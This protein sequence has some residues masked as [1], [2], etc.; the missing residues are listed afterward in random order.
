MKELAGLKSLHSLELFGTDVTD[1]GLKELAG[2][3]SLRWLDLGQTQVT[4]A[5]LDDLHALESLQ[6]LNLRYTQ[7]TVAGVAELLKALP[8]LRVF[9]NAGHPVQERCQAQR[10]S[11]AAEA[12]HLASERLSLAGCTEFAHAAHT[13]AC[14]VGTDNRKDV[15]VFECKNAGSFSKYLSTGYGALQ[16]SLRGDGDAVGWPGSRA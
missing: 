7:V 5:G 10:R 1:I 3:K 8:G 11:F 6:R 12:R 13:A 2:V 4:D 16:D 9:H 14:A 15:W